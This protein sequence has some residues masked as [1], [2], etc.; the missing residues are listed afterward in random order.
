L[1]S[2]TV[3]FGMARRLAQRLPFY[4]GWVI[5]YISFLGVFLMG[6]TTYWGLQVFVKPMH[7]DT[8][9]SHASIIAGLFARFVAGAVVA[10]ILGRVVDQRFGP[11]KLMLVGV[12]ID[13]IAL[14]SL[15]WVENPT[16]F[17]LAYGVL[18][19]F[20]N[21]G[22]RLVQAALVPK[23]FVLK[24]GA[25]V[26]FATMGGG[27][28]ALIMVPV[29]SLTIDQLG[30]R[31][32]WVAIAV[33]MVVLTLPC[34]P[35]AVRAPEDIGLVP[36]NGETPKLSSRAPRVTADTE[37]NFTLGEA[38]RTWRLW[39]VL[40]AISLG[41]YSLGANT[42]VLVP[43]YEEIGFSSAIA[44]SAVSIYG[45]ASITTRYIWGQ[46]ADRFSVRPAIIVQ[47]LLTAAGALLLLQIGSRSGLYGVS[48]L[49]GIALSGFPTLQS[50]VWPEFF[51]RRHIGA[52]V[53]LTQLFTTL[54]SASGPLIGGIIFDRTG[55]YE[56]TIWAFVVTWIA[57]AVVI[58]AVR[59]T[60]HVE[61]VVVGVIEA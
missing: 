32:A 49:E 24:R 30:W 29:I 51:G 46:M 36:D 2:D 52:I 20:G 39:F 31:D 21:S 23:W 58:F 56:A 55:T 16:Q 17:V 14:I 41:S 4:Y 22:L 57:C 11:R 43:Y 33:F 47:S 8:G 27:V 40:L 54:A 3:E 6:A 35:F 12:L 42:F 28:S 10:F 25:A 44:A 45:L 15:R 37:R 13:A 18:G 50:L 48:V 26:A 53:G 59:P 7:D 9:W 60:R 19:G 34:V 5:V 38:L 61:P 1:T